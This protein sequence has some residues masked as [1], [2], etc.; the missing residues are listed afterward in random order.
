M[1]DLLYFIWA[2]L[3][4]ALLWITMK[5][6]AKKVTNTGNREYPS[7]YLKQLIYS[8]IALIIAIIVDTTIFPSVSELLASYGIEPRVVRW[9]IY[10][11]ILTLG[12]VIQE[13]S[14]KKENAELEAE[15]KARRMKYAKK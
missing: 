1:P 13:I 12:A 14:I 5:A 3:P 7:N 4:V 8:T 11:A 6:A 2:L 10:P 9:L 15:K